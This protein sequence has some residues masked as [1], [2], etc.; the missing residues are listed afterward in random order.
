[1]VTSIAR[2][3]GSTTA[4]LAGVTVATTSVSVWLYRAT[5]GM[6]AVAI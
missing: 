4:V 3:V 6:R 5:R 1:V 2:V